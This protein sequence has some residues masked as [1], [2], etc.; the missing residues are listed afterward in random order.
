MM[1]SQ[2]LEPTWVHILAPPFTS[3]VNLGKS[4]SVPQLPMK[5]G[6]QY[7]RVMWFL[8]GLNGVTHC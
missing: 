1:K 4:L 5:W 2:V 7:L 8:Q 3:H 6:E